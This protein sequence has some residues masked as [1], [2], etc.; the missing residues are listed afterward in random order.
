VKPLG[1]YKARVHKNDLAEWMRS[2]WDVDDEEL[3]IG[4][5]RPIVWRHAWQPLAWPV[6]WRVVRAGRVWQ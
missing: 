1:R 3:P 6:G 4:D 2:S 5:M